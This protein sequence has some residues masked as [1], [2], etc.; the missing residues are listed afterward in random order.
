MDILLLQ[1]SVLHLPSS[2]RASAIV[3]D[4]TSDLGLWRPLGPDRELWDA[5]GDELRNVLDK[6]R[7]RLPDHQLERG[8]LLRLH[9][10][11][12]HCDFL[13]WVASRSPHGDT[14]PAAAPSVEMVQDLAR[15]V[16]EFVAQHDVVRVAFPALGAGRGEAAA[17]DRMAA[18]VRAVS[19]YKE[20]CF[21]EERPAHIEEVIICDPSSANVTKTKRMVERLARAGYAEPAAPAAATPA[22]AKRAAGEGPARKRGAPRLRP[23]DIASAR[24]R[25]GTY[26][27]SRAYH[28]GEFF[29]HPTFGVGQVQLVKPERMVVVLFEDGLE[30]TMIHAR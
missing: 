4:G 30:R 26:D 2:K 24:A 25:S 23:D 18:I 5:Y 28:E 14:E 7:K 6:E 13:I 10:G 20:A 8:G 21:A 15:R 16:I 27:R 1:A 22:K 29:I 17:S 9:P 3:Y 11:K 12:L 19:A